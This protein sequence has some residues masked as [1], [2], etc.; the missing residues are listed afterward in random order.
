VVISA[1]P[2]GAAW[3][4]V[5]RVPLTTISGTLPAGWRGAPRSSASWAKPGNQRSSCTWPAGSS[6]CT[7]LPCGTPGRGTVTSAVSRSTINTSRA[8]SL[9]TRAAISPA[10]LPP[11]TTARS[12]RMRGP[13]G[14]SEVVIWANTFDGDGTGSSL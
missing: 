3:P 4:D 11:S 5:R 10:M 13:V 9:S 6:A 12:I 1:G 2:A 8:W 7:W 14:R